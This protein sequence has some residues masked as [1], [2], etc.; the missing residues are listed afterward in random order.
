ML[1]LIDVRKVYTTKAGDTIA[2]K[3]VSIKFAD[4]GMVFI[5]G[6]SGSGKTTLLNSIG[7]LD[8]I[9]GGEIIVDGKK[10][11]EFTPADYDSYRNTMV[12]FVFQEYNLLN[13]YSIE[14]N[15]NI[16]DEL[17]GRNTDEKELNALLRKFEI[18]EYE[19]RKPN[20]LSGGQKQRVAIARALIKNP[21]I[22]LAD[23]PTGAL[24]SNTG[25]Q[26]MDL[27][28]E[29][30]K[31]KLVIVVSHELSFAEKYADRIIRIVDGQVVEDVTLSDVAVNDNIYD[32]EQE[33]IVKAGA[34]LNADETKKLVGAVEEKKKIRLTENITVRQKKKTE[35][36]EDDK[37]QKTATFIKSRMKLKS[38]ATLGMKSLV[39]K[40]FRLI[41]T[42][43]LSVIAFA[44]FG[45]FDSVASYNGERAL[46]KLLS[47]GEYGSVAIYNTYSSKDYKNARLKMSQDYLDTL[48]RQTGYSFRGVYE[49]N[50]EEKFRTSNISGEKRENFN[51]GYSPKEIT[52]SFYKAKEYYNHQINGFIEFDWGD[53]DRDGTIKDY[54]YKIIPNTGVNG[55]EPSFPELAE[56]G[57]VQSVGI[58]KY[59]AE[60]LRFWASQNNNKYAGENISSI[61]DLYGLP[62]TINNIEYKISAIID[63]GEVPEK[64]ETL[65][66][67]SAKDDD[68]YRTLAQD[69]TTYL[70]SSCNLSI[71]VPTGFV[72][73]YRAQNNRVINYVG[74]YN[75][76]TYSASVRGNE[77]NCALP[78]FY[79]VD[80]FTNLN[81]VFFD[82]TSSDGIVPTLKENQ[83]LV[84]YRNILEFLYR[85]DVEAGEET[86]L[87]NEYISSLNREI[88]EEV[89]LDDLNTVENEREIALLAR[90]NA[91]S[92]SVKGI[93][94]VIKNHSG[95]FN[96]IK[97][98]T[99]NVREL[100]ADKNS[101]PALSKKFEVV[102]I[103]FDVANDRSTFQTLE[104]QPLVLS[105]DGLKSINITTN[106][107]Y[108][109]RAI[110]TINTSK[111]GANRLSAMMS[112]NSGD[113]LVWFE[114]GILEILNE[115]AEFIGQFLEL[116]LYIAIV[117]VTFSIFMLFNY[118]STS[119]V[120]KRQSI[121]VLRALGTGGKSIFL[122]FLLES[123]VISIISGLLASLVSYIACIFVNEYILEVMNLTIK[124]VLFG[125]RQIAIIVASSMVTG[126]LASLMPIIRI[127]K[128]KPVALIRKD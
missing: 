21:K 47:S 74:D 70:N 119:I 89:P 1:E 51:A 104:V 123:L 31:E 5:S 55:F 105:L 125:G 57:A 69:F 109:S 4:K 97:E 12:G 75:A 85:V 2:L 124:F 79:N 52:F 9:D 121:G 20:Q 58:S 53:F 38:V 116:F 36:I 120:S 8:K 80:E 25:I 48:N 14:K 13:E 68:A 26:V 101:E 10:F 43:L 113:K 54:N 19:K 67:V 86:K 30:S 46:S 3:G 98:L 23:E 112:K 102:G 94:N 6:K 33:I 49:L 62:L 91:I 22:I 59:Y 61:V 50:D 81:T 93:I 84:S 99:L 103:Y 82:D 16:A 87:V 34:K 96:H 107:G 71:F 64:Y 32:G 95:F 73:Q 7:G 88:S 127:V 66:T 15:I 18:S 77:Q 39:V 44:V 115:N 35:K 45:V 56:A 63:C 17:Q 106:Q 41:I 118:I 83:A 108:Y 128:E 78:I 100:G 60:N 92:T 114:N 24:D 126:F 37:N 28:K 27:L 40:P 76:V 110:S 122:M 111:I 29:L 42:I 90:R 65:R 11:S 117:M 72:E